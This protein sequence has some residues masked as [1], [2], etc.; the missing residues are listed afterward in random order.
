MPIRQSHIQQDDVHATFRKMNDGFAHA[1]EVRQFETVG[2]LLAEH[3]AEYTGISRVILN[4]KNLECFFFHACAPCCNLTTGS[5]KLSM[6]FSVG[7]SLISPRTSRPSFLGRSG[8]GTLACWPSRRSTVIASVPS[9]ASC[10][11]TRTLASL[12][13]SCVNR[14]QSSTTRISI[15]AA[16]D[17]LISRIFRAGQSRKLSLSLLRSRTCRDRRMHL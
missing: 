15:G 1:Q 5:Q 2:S 13:A 16:M 9:D 10:R 14:T 8:Q 11:L 4:Q 17:S 7:P 12:S 3:L 6:L